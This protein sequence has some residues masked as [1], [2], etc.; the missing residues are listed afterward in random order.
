MNSLNERLRQLVE[1]EPDSAPPIDRL[2][3][4]GRRARRLRRTATVAMSALAV[5]AIGA[6]AALVNQPQ[7]AVSPPVVQAQADPRLEL[8]AALAS[9][10]NTSFKV[11]ATIT[12]E[13]AGKRNGYAADGACDPAAANGYLKMRDGGRETLLINGTKYDSKDGVR[14][15]KREGTWSHIGFDSLALDG[16]LIGSADS[17]R[18]F[19]M[20]RE[21]D[22]RVTKTGDRTFHFE[23]TSRRA[24]P[25]SDIVAALA[26]DIVLDGQQRVE[27]LDYD[28]RVEAWGFK[29]HGLLEF[30]DYGT[31]VRVKPPTEVINIG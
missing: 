16:D 26:G 19:E 7:A 28:Y 31:P 6:A 22:A 14:F 9:T 27:R 21:A 30:S 10:E 18:L 29:M 17:Q 1:A 13:I 12:R 23:A 3:E 11:R 4:R 24:V 20:L 5:G 8:V 15:V 2:L 25:A